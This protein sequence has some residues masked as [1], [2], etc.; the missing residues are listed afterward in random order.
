MLVYGKN[1][2]LD[3]LKN[4]EFKKMYL[5]KGFNDSKILSFISKNV[6]YVDKFFL[7]KLCEGGLHQGI[8]IEIPD[9][10]YCDLS[11]LDVDNGLIV[12]LDHLE[13]PHNFGAIIRTSE[14]LGVDGIIIPKDRSVDVNSTVIK[15]S[16]GTVSRMKI[17]KV[18]NLNDTIMNLKKLGYWFVGTDMNGQD[19]DKID[20]K[21]KIAIIIGNEGKGMSD[22]VRK[23]C[24]FIASIP[25]SGSVNSLNA[26]VAFGIILSNAVLNRK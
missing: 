22:S 16:A 25:M 1:A 15:T 8:A 2:C 7:D 5:E 9:Y 26:S 10:K 17:C 3:Y 6:Q 13:D 20:Y 19:Y 21:G 14:A 18:T 24:D 4:N 23:N 12:V 11:E